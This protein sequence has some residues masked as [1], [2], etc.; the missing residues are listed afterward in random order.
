MGEGWGDGLY[1]MCA[2]IRHRAERE[3]SSLLPWDNSTLILDPINLEMAT[4]ILIFI[5]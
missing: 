2:R 1:S 4:C 5:L 3:F